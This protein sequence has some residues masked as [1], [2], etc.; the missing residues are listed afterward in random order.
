MKIWIN[1]ISLQLFAHL[2]S[3]RLARRLWRGIRLQKVDAGQRIRLTAN[4]KHTKWC[5]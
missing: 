4:A 1:E 3:E 2:S 5:R